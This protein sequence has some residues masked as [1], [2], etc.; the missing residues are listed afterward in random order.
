MPV[1]FPLDQLK[2][3]VDLERQKQNYSAASEY[4]EGAL[5]LA[6]STFIPGW[7]GN[8]HV[9]L[10]EVAIDKNSFEEAKVFLEQ[11]EAHYKNTHPRHSPENLR[12][13]SCLRVKHRFMDD[14][15][16]MLGPVFEGR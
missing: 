1:S 7:L 13:F 6:R 5:E 9:G 2:T 14:W 3:G 15:W 8:L 16:R 4:L 10:A 11:A 12:L